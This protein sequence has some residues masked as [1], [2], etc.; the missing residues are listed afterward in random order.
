MRM[1]KRNKCIYI[2]K[3]IR[4]GRNERIKNG[5]KKIKH[6]DKKTL[7]NAN[8]LRERERPVDKKI[9][10]NVEILFLFGCTCV[11]FHALTNDL[12]WRPLSC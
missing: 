5:L 2:R 4:S 9:G 6:K 3:R 8:A 1:Q 10:E 11:Y 12:E 7:A